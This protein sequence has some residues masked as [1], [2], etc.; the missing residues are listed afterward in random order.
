MKSLLRSPEIFLPI[1][2]LA[3]CLL[4]LTSCVGTRSYRYEYRR[5]YSATPAGGG[6]ASAPRKAPDAVRRAIAAGNEI[7]GS[8]YR[9]GGGHGRGL[10]SGYD[11][12]GAVSYVL[13]R[14][15]LL[16]GPMTSA[17]FRHYGSRG[18]G[19]WITVYARHGHVLLVVADLRY[20]TGWHEY[21]EGP[22][23]TTR[24]RPLRGYV[25]RHPPGL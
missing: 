2:L 1:C 16:G 12:S 10:D 19:K 17:E 5:G 15:G 25:A 3:A 20:D 22:H 8:P 24:S 4:L 21:P 7:A 11:C 9:Y 14:A 18:I 6:L 13:E 23:W